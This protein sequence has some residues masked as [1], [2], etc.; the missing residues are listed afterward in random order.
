MQVKSNMKNLND[1]QG[2]NLLQI[3]GKRTAE[4][5]INPVLRNLKES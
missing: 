2:I 1:W 4:A 3:L 5:S